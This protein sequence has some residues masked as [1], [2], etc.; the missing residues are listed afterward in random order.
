MNTKRSG[1]VWI[2]SA[3]VLATYAL[4]GLT[5]LAIPGVEDLVGWLAKAEGWE[6]YVAGFVA[7]LLEGL[8]IIGN[9][10]PGTTM[11]LLLAVLSGVGGWLQFAITILAIFLGWS[12][13]GLINI[14]VAHRSLNRDLHTHTSE[15]IVKDQLLLT[16]LPAFRANHEVAQIAAGA[17]LIKVII[18]SFRVRF[19]ASLAA[20]AVAALVMFFVDI[21]SIENEEGFASVIVL[22]FIMAL[23]GWKQIKAQ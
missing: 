12:I 16:W 2:F 13:A 19:I 9:L 8:Y 23:V 4:L 22:A 21:T 1:Y 7:I 20:A 11:V 3:A 10:F 18:S 14:Y 17:P 15:I 5:G 6:F